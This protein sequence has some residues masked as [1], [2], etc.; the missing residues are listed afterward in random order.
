MFRRFSYASE[1]TLSDFTARK[2]G[3][4][5]AFPEEKRMTRAGAHIESARI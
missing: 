5:L 3:G 1:Q 2:Y 4:K